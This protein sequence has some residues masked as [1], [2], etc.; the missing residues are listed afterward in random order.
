MISQEMV[1]HFTVFHSFVEDWVSA[2]RDDIGVITYEGNSPKD[3]FKVT[4]GVHNPYNL[5]VANKRG[6]E[7][8]V[9]TRSALSVNTTSSKI[10][11]RKPTRS[12]EE[13]AE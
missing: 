2:D 7:K 6:Y 4:H 1:S 5:R 9:G 8:M 3:H 10:S 13:E 12:S 11:I